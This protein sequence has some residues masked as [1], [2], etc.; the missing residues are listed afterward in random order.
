MA[1]TWTN[2]ATGKIEG[3]DKSTSIIKE[4]K[5]NIQSLYTVLKLGTVTYTGD[6]SDNKI[7]SS[8]ITELRTKIDYA[9]TNRNYCG[10]VNSAY[11]TSNY[12]S[13]YSGDNTYE[14]AY[15]NSSDQYGYYSGDDTSENGS[16][17]YSYD[18]T[19]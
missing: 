13:Y 8:N 5:T 6:M 14:D 16:D 11:Y 10:T 17:Y 19:I 1:F 7:L 12:G 3:D 2:S 15:D 9:H 18:V 4:I